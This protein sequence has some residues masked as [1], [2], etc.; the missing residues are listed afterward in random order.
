[1]AP[2]MAS[3]GAHQRDEVQ[4][5]QVNLQEFL[6]VIRLHWDFRAPGTITIL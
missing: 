3:L 4:S 1:M 5:M 6:Q 2:S